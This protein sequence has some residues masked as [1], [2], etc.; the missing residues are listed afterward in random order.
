MMKQ[1][2]VKEMSALIDE[3][4]PIT[5]E[6]FSEMIEETLIDERKRSAI[7]IPGDVEVDMLDWCYSPIVQ[8]G[9]NFDLRSS[10]VSDKEQLHAGTILCSFGAR[11]KSYCSNIGRTY[12]IDPQKA[13]SLLT[14]HG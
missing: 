2:F 1:F 10:A 5:H 12:L 3:E 9:G 6:K 11:Y 14:I 13:S 7:R 4:R 8:S